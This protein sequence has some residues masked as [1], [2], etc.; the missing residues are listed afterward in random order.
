MSP[1][2]SPATSIDVG[3]CAASETI[4]AKTESSVYELIIRRGDCGDVLVRGG[5]YFA[6]FCPVIFLGSITNDGVVERHTIDIGLRMAFC[7]NDRIIAT[8]KVESLS[9]HPAS[10]ARAACAATR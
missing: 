5:N 9:R 2:R 1:A 3:S 6:D 4:V 10:D 8:S 7:F